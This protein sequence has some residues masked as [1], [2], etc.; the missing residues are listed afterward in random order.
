MKLLRLLCLIFAALS[1]ALSGA[2]QAEEAPALSRGQTLYLPIYSSF[3]HGDMKNGYPQKSQ[4]S[5]L[6]SVRNTDPRQSIRLT[7]ARYYDTAGRLVA[8]YMKAPKTIGPLATYELYV[9]K[10]E[11]AGGSG[12]NFLIVWQA[13]APTNP[14]V[15]EAVHA[16]LL[17]HRTLVFITSGHPI[18]PGKAD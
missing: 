1:F 10:Q 14:P 17:G 2:G 12:A 16:D 6:V 9:E 15:V 3:W 11:A 13:E 7:S 18:N 8:E 5:A 4:V